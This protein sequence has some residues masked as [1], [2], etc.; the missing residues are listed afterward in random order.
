MRRWESALSYAVPLLL[1]AVALLQIYRAHV[2][3]QSPWKGG[4]F[5][6][7]STVDSPKVRY[8]RT[9]VVTVEGEELE[10]TPPQRLNLTI[11]RLEVIPSRA[12]LAKVGDTVLTHRWVWAD[13]DPLPHMLAEA[14]IDV[15]AAA[16]APPADPAHRRLRLRKH[17]EPDPPPEA[18]VRLAAA[19]VEL[20]RMSYDG[21]TRK[22]RAERMDAVTRRAG[23]RAAAGGATARAAGGDG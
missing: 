4:G 6:M 17:G 11:E 5:G 18:R 22:L 19:R 14:G 16:Y 21:A 23:G 10:V 1:V 13:Y 3:D 15:G 7:F 2:Y 8:V 12:A 9:F 20:W